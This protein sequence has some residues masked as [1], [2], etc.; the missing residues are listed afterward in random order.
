MVIAI[1]VAFVVVIHLQCLVSVYLSLVKIKYS[2][3]VCEKKKRMIL[4]KVACN[5][6]YSIEPFDFR[7]LVLLSI[8]VQNWDLRLGCFN[9][10]YTIHLLQYDITICNSVVHDKHHWYM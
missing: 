3:C 8:E 9:Q 1:I 7:I 2:V 5:D 6:N 4:L 10:I